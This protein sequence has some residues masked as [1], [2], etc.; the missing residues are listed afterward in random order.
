MDFGYTEVFTDT[1][2]KQYGEGLGKIISDFSD[3]L[4]HTGKARN[5]LHALE[6]RYR[7]E[8]KVYKANNIREYNL[9]YQKK[10]KVRHKAQTALA[11]KVNNGFNALY[12]EKAPAILIT[13]NLR[14]VFTFDRPKGVNRKLSSWLNLVSVLY[15]RIYFPTFSNS[16]KGLANYLGFAWTSAGA[17][18]LQALAWRTEWEST[19]DGSKFKAH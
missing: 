18:G 12:A 10:D 2:G 6:K 15:S 14:H 9:G 8:G 3:K 5:R 16:L 7:E 19:K 17:S 1:E 11:S 13:E 4:N